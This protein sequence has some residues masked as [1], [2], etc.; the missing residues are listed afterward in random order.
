MASQLAVLDVLVALY[1]LAVLL[2]MLAVL[3]VL[4]V[5]PVPAMFCVQQLLREWPMS[6][7]QPPPLPLACCGVEVL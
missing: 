2:Y 3:Y 1:V 4:A 5:V 7:Y 6:Y